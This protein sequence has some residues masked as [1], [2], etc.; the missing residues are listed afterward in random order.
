MP[1]RARVVRRP[2]IPDAKFHSVTVQRFI[3]KVMQRGK[4]S[5]AERII[6]GSLGTVEDQIE[7]T[8]RLHHLDASD[9]D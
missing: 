2:I 7:T 8:V 1:R 4:K 3:N 5:T 9:A 6:Y